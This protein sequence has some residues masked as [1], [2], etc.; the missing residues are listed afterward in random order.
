[1]KNLFVLSGLIPSAAAQPL[2]IKGNKA[3]TGGGSE[4]EESL[5]DEMSGDDE[6]ADSFEPV[7][8]VTSST[9]SC[10][11]VKIKTNLILNQMDNKSRTVFHHLACSLEYGSFCNVEIAKLLFSAFQYANE[12]Q[13]NLKL[14]PLSEF[15]KRV[16]S[17]VK[18]ASDYALKNGNIELN[19][20]FKRQ[21]NKSAA[22]QLSQSELEKFIVN[23]TFY[24]AAV[25]VDY[26]KDSAEFL[27]T[28]Q[29]SNQ[30]AL[31]A[32]KDYFTVDSL[33]NMHKIG[34]LVWDKRFNVPY[35]VILTKTDVSY[36][37][38][39]IHNFYKIQLITHSYNN[40]E[41]KQQ[42]IC[43][44][45]TRWGRIGDQGQCQRTPFASTAVA[46]DEFAK[47]FKQKT[48]NDFVD[49]VLEKKKPFESK[50][51]RYS[52]VKLELRRRPKL[53]DIDFSL[54]DTSSSSASLVPFNRSVFAKHSNAQDYRQFWL[55]LLDVAYLKSRIH[56][57]AIISGK[58]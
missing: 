39:G 27:R 23:D 43:V 34:R 24:N 45:F 48:G 14:P 11:P 55:D 36:G 29:P 15:L 37:L 10:Q 46:K 30:D 53:K 17:K 2:A 33:S 56:K 26:A 42:Q 1:M 16:D 22:I 54:F 38:Y 32:D 6:D 9:S 5:G 8:K 25:R 13:P 7:I 3:K 52:L 28:Q 31:A 40:E 20:E 35:D 47:L 19:E 51:R 44:L 4:D 50:P 49:T 18:T 21:L 58:I 12:H 57:S 41:D